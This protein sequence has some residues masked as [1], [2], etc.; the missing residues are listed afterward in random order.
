MRSLSRREK[1]SRVSRPRGV[2]SV[3]YGMYRFW[4]ELTL[5][6]SPRCRSCS[7]CRSISGSC[8]GRVRS[9]AVACLVDD[10]R[11]LDQELERLPSGD[12]RA[13]R[14]QDPPPFEIAPQPFGLLTGPFGQARDLGVELRRRWPRW[15]PAPRLRAMRGRRAR[16]ATA[17]SR[18]SS[19][20]SSVSAAGRLEVLLDR[21][22]AVLQLVDEIGDALLELLVDERF[23]RRDRHEVGGRLQ[24]A[25][26]HRHLR[27]HARHQVE[28][29][30]NV[31]AQLGERLELA[32]LRDPLV[33]RGREA[34]FFF[35]S[36]TITR[37]VASLPASS[38]KRSGKRVGELEDRAG[39]RAVQ[40]RVERRHDVADCRPRRGS[41]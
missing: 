20:N 4:G 13:Y 24:H 6:D 16:P 38:P 18:S 35:A 5:P 12:L 23:G 7:R 26:A 15:L 33:G 19:T 21:D 31:V 14:L 32:H 11:V 28:A 41:R 37:N 36:F 9:I 2:S 3:T 17:P 27:L 34:T 40:L 39:R 8:S 10:A 25:I 29:L 22:P 30:A 1:M